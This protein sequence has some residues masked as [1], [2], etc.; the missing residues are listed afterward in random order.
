MDYC[1]LNERMTTSTLTLRRHKFRD[2]ILERDGLFCVVT[3]H[4]AILCDAAHLVPRSKGDNV[5]F[6]TKVLCDSH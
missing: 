3:G 1:G 2:E 5:T 6:T 4:E